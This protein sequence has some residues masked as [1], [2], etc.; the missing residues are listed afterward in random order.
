MSHPNPSHDPENVREADSKFAPR[1]NKG[2][3]K[4]KDPASKS[5]AIKDKIKSLTHI[6][7]GPAGM[8]N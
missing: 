2:R 6:R 7:R 1:K 8:Y 4:D 3:R 5:Y